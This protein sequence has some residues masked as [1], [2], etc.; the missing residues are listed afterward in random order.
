[1]SSLSSLSIPFVCFFPSHAIPRSLSLSHP[2]SLSLFLGFDI[3]QSFS[4]SGSLSLFFPLSLALFLSFL[5]TIIQADLSRTL[6]TFAI[7]IC[8]YS[9]LSRST[10]TP[11]FRYLFLCS[12]PSLSFLVHPSR[13]SVPQS[14]PPGVCLFDAFSLSI[15]LPRSYIFWLAGCRAYTSFTYLSTA[16]VRFRAPAFLWT[17]GNESHPI[18][19]AIPHLPLVLALGPPPLAARFLP[20][21]A[22]PSFAAPLSSSVRA[23]PAACLCSCV[24]NDSSFRFRDERSFTDGQPRCALHRE[25]IR[26]WPSLLRA[27]KTTIR[28]ISLFRSR[29]LAFQRD[30]CDSRRN[31]IN[32]LLLLT[33]Y[34]PHSKLHEINF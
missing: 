15:S 21:A 30:F 1:M 17:G 9:F 34:F 5:S 27:V 24:F 20:A 26:E 14:A 10:P 28:Q 13:L 25:E 22:I 11:S 8:L 12:S 2:F 32:F 7:S 23:D 4:R 33:E 18:D 29:P 31:R 19:R 6:S 16:P 3:S